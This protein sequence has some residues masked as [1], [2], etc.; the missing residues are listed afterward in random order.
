[1][2]DALPASP[3]R[4]L[5]VADAAELL[6]VTPGEVLDVIRSGELVAIAVGHARHWRI[7]REALEGYIAALYEHSRR[8]S[9]WHQAEFTDL[10]E[11]I[12]PGPSRS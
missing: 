4:F 11:L 9:L 2:T 8:M 5:T 10:P 12:V 7:E 3:G 6:R 1:M